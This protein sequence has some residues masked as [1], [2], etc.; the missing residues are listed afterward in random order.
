MLIINVCHI[1]TI[2]TAENFW[3]ILNNFQIR[4]NERFMGKW[5]Y[6]LRVALTNSMK[7]YSSVKYLFAITMHYFFYYIK[8]KR[9]REYIYNIVVYKDANYYI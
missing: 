9:E 1:C 7:Y 6:L 8:K 2:V 5:L 4:C 3:I